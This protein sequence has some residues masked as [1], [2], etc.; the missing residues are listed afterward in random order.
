MNVTTFVRLY[1]HLHHMAEAGSWKSIQQIGLLTTR[2]LV[3]DCNPD[4]TVREAILGRRRRTQFTLT[5]PVIGQVTI[6]DQKPLMMHNLEP[7]LTDMTVQQ[8]LE[9]LNDRVFLWAHPRRL[10]RL[11]DARSYRDSLHDVLIVDTARLVEAHADRIRITGM[12]AGATIFPRAP[13]RG[14]DTFQQIDTFPFDER[15]RGG[16]AVVDNVVE[17]CVLGGLPDVADFV[18]RVECRKGTSVV[19]LLY[20]A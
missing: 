4:A 16:K 6:R 19:E 15:R 17:V 13:K 8:W 11:L 2:Q 12:N 9:S 14:S 18:I 20:E 10:T 3:D 1:P 5:H 7:A